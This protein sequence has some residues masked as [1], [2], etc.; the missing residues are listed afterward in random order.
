LTITMPAL[1]RRW[2]SRAYF[3]EVVAMP[4]ERPNSTP[5]AISSASS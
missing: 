5:L 1:A 2:K 3:S 4:A